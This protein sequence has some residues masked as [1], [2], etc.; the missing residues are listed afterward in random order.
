LH[1]FRIRFSLFKIFKKEELFYHGRNS[2]PEDH[3]AEEGL[4]SVLLIQQPLEVSAVITDL[5]TFVI[6]KNIL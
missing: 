3:S 1:S 2:Y 4:G 5:I 6:A